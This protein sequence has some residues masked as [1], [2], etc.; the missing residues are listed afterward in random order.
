[1]KSGVLVVGHGSKLEYNKNLVT[2]M[3]DI[4]AKR[5]EFGPVAIAFIQYDE[6]TIKEGIW[7]LAEQRC[8]IPYMSNLAS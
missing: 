5:N 6:P 8:S 3:A 7:T 2:H 1:M 4:I